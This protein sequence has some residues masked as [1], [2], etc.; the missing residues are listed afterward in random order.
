MFKIYYINARIMIYC[1]INAFIT[2]YSFQC[3]TRRSW[4]TICSY[5]T[6]CLAYFP[7]QLYVFN[8][9]NVNRACFKFSP[10]SPLTCF[11]FSFSIY[12][13]VWLPPP[14]LLF[15]FKKRKNNPMLH[16]YISARCTQNCE[17]VFHIYLKF[18]IF[19]YV[20]MLC[21][22]VLD[23]STCQRLCWNNYRKH[24]EQ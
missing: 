14:P 2:I 23:K 4:N 12:F 11:S 16:L 5:A 21:W 20:Y 6:N 10:F 9:F 3:L 22:Y 18:L 15:D 1:E 7:A 19:I 8:V 24:C 17:K 13:F